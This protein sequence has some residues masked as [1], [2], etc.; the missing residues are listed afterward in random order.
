MAII[1]VTNWPNDNNMWR[2]PVEGQ[3]PPAGY[4]FNEIRNLWFL[5]EPMTERMELDQQE[6]LVYYGTNPSGSITI[7]RAN[8]LTQEAAQQYVDYCIS[9][10]GI[11]CSL[12]VNA[13]E[14]P[15][16]GDESWNPFV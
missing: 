9:I 7:C 1:T 2:T 15:P 6:Y 13:D 3:E 16:M 5:I 11:N 12:V 10:G 14:T 4:Y 8:W